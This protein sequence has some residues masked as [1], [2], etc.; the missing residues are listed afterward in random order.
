MWSRT[1]Y[2]TLNGSPSISVVLI[3]RVPRSIYKYSALTDQCLSSLTSAP[4]PTAKPALV[5][6]CDRAYDVAVGLGP[7]GGG[8]PVLPTAPGCEKLKLYL[9]SPTARPPVTNSNQF[10]AGL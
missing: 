3:V 8:A 1:R 7:E 4:P 2:D 6:L 9:L 5:L 10:S